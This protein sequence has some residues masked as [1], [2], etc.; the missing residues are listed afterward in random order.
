M[1]APHVHGLQL[2]VSPETPRPRE[3]LCLCVCKTRWCLSRRAD[4]AK[5]GGSGIQNQVSSD[6]HPLLAAY[7]HVATRFLAT[8]NIEHCTDAGAD[9]VI[10]SSPDSM[11]EDGSDSPSGRT[12]MV[13]EISL[14]PMEWGRIMRVLFE[15]VSLAGSV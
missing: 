8:P 15:K 10:Q 7:I 4:V 9:A 3:H 6:D 11:H 5:E 14:H 2:R 12:L 1:N 13:V